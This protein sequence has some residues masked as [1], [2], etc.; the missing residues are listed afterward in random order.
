[1]T[2][3]AYDRDSA[4]AAARR[5]G[6]G[7]CR[8]SSGSAPASRAR[9]ARSISSGAASTL[10]SPAFRAATAP[11]HPGGIPGLPDRITREAY[12]HEVSSAGFWPGGVDRRRADLLQ[13]RLSRARRLPRRAASRRRRRGSTRR[14]A[15]SSCPMRRCARSADPGGDA[16]ALPPVDLRRRRQPAPTGTAQRWSGSRS[17][18]RPATNGKGEI[19]FLSPVD[20]QH[21][22]GRRRGAIA[23]VEPRADGAGRADRGHRRIGQ[24][25]A[26]GAATVCAHGGC[27]SRG[28]SPAARPTGRS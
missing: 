9:P 1:M 14:S 22:P 18:L 7:S 5:A 2:P 15:N 21:P 11:Q 17:R 16:D 24:V 6:R 12:S 19:V 8:S 20:R 13:L 4:D 27:R 28:R 23:A 3:R 26:L 10:P 25:I